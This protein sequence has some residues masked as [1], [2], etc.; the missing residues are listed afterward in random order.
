MAEYLQSAARLSECRRY[1]YTLSRT[2][3]A[4]PRVCWLML[5]PSTADGRE[6]DPTIRRCVDFARKFGAS[7][8]LVV[9]LFAL[10]ATDPMELVGADD[11]VGPGNNDVIADAVH[12]SNRLVL[13]AWGAPSN[14]RLRALVA[15]RAR[16]VVGVLKNDRLYSLGTTKDGSPR[17]PLYLPASTMPS[18]WTLSEAR[19]A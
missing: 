7:S 15:A 5:N 14:A 19:H 2:W 17:H 13:C 16:A 12:A 11:P 10:R 4:G 1:R 6:D 18:R 8:M 3:G 9:N